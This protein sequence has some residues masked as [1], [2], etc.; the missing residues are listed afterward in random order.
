MPIIPSL[1]PVQIPK[2]FKTTAP[3]PSPKRHVENIYEKKETKN[4]KKKKL[5][6][7]KK[8]RAT[9]WPNWNSRTI[10]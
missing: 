9:P 4:I 6:K 3:T 5:L 7:E 2:L 1:I 10:S 8:K